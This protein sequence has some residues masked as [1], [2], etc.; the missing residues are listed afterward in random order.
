MN[1]DPRAEIIRAEG[2]TKR[3]HGL[4]AVNNVNFVLREFDVAGIIGSNGAGKTTFFNIL[5]GLYPPEEGKVF[6]KGEDVTRMP[7]EKRVDLGMMRT[8]QL[9]ATFDSLSVVDNLVLSF[10]RAHKKPSLLSLFLNT[11]KRHRNDPKIVE[12]LETFDLKD[13]RDR[14]VK[15][16]SLGEKRRLEIAMSILADPS[17][18]LLDEPLAGLAE[19]EIQMLLKVLRAHVGRQTILIVEHKLSH[20]QD[21]LQRLTV[22]HEGRVIAEG[23][24]EECLRHPEVRKSYWQI[25]T[26]AEE[27]GAAAS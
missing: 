4:V 1:T 26:P 9:T 20:V 14:I 8:F 10:F 3:F 12:I 15:N 16:L 11:C 27:A 13:I 22:M 21:F 5:T 19:S 18:L 2:V 6:Y 25:A 17:L 24:C 7:P 23:P